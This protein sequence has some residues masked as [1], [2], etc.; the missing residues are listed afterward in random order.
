[1]V[2]MATL[3]EQVEELVDYSVNT[4]SIPQ[5]V[6]HVKS[7][8]TEYYMDNKHKNALMEQHTYMLDAKER[9]VHA[10]FFWTD[11]NEI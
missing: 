4:M 7:S 9:G 5:L 8:L 10:N 6:A 1:M 11:L 3:K 2:I